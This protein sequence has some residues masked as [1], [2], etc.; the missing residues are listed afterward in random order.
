MKRLTLF[1]V[2]G[3]LLSSLVV[4]AP[5]LTATHVSR[6]IAAAVADPHRPAADRTRDAERKP[7]A[8]V[9]FA[10]VHRV[11]TIAELFPGSGYFTRIFSRVV[12]P[13]GHVYEFQPKPRKPGATAPVAAIAAILTTIT[14][15]R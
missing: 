14:T 3:L 5:A 2:A 13:K 9:A 1:A 10:G 8:C 15:S 11:E 12:G 7:A 6:A 4:P